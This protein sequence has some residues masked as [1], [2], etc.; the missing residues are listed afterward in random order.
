VRANREQ[1]GCRLCATSLAGLLLTATEILAQTSAT[2][3]GVAPYGN[4]HAAGVV[5]TIAGDIDGDSSATLE[6]RRTGE[7]AFQLAH[8]LVRIGPTRFVGSLFGL[9]PGGSWQAR[10]TL[11]DPDGVSGTPTQTAGFST[12]SP[13]LAEPTLRTL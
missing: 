8:P 4:F 9:T 3:V 5:A 1:S 11:A 6:W 12:R 7:P 13:L 2:L 10:V